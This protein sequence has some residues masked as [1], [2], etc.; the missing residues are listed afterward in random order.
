MVDFSVKVCYNEDEVR[1]VICNFEKLSFQILTIDRFLHKA[2]VFDVK[3]RP[4]AA[5]SF[6]T[7]GEGR[8]QIAGK[9]FTVCE[10]DFLFIPAGAPYRVEY[11]GGESIVVHL[12]DCNYKEAQS[13]KLQNAA[14]VGACFQKLLAN[15]NE[16]HSVNRAKSL[17]FEILDRVAEDQRG[18]I[19]DTAFAACVAYI[20]AHFCDAALTVE[21]VAAR[22]FISPCGLQRKF[23]AYFATSPKQYITKLRMNKALDLLMVGE[24]SVCEVA[25]A[26]GFDDEK[27]FSR[28]FRKIYGYP[29]SQLKKHIVI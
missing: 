17:V 9:S 20:D 27:Y 11:S 13:I 5:I 16:R 14:G 19:G 10:G 21:E 2:G 1:D 12:S 26:S 28:A 29:P 4:Y 3:A 22:G 6:R 15:W 23:H 25:R 8:F 7:K 18:I 24:L